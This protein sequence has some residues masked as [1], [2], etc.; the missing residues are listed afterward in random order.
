MAGAVP[1]LQAP[2]DGMSGPADGHGGAG[3]RRVGR[4][5]TAL[6]VG[7]LAGLALVLAYLAFMASVEEVYIHAWSELVGWPGLPILLVPAVLVIAEI[8]TGAARFWRGLALLA[9]ALVTGAGLGALIGSVVASHPSAPWAGALMGAGGGVALVTLGLAVRSF[10]S[11]ALPVMVL[12]ALVAACGPTREPAREEARVAPIS[13]SAA[14][15]SVISLMG[16]IPY[17]GGCRPRTR[18]HDSLRVVSEISLLGGPAAYRAVWGET[19]A[20]GS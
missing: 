1:I 12:L 19:L 18:P 5:L 8:R 10:R 6:V 4:L 14:V 11:S 2:G 17:P 7:V 9:G 16:D 3:V 13:D 20:P 15:E